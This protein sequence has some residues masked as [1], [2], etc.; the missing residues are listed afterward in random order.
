MPR[1]L[2]YQRYSRRVRRTANQLFDAVA[3]VAE[4]RLQDT[5]SGRARATV[6][7]VVGLASEVL[8][9]AVFAGYALGAVWLPM[10]VLVAVTVLPV[11]CL[12]L[13]APRLLPPVPAGRASGT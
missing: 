6:S 10:S 13:V 3:I 11:V 12:G 9:V 5:M 8:S 7:S 2:N 4:A 1:I